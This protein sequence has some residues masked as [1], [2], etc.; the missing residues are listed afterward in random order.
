MAY[1]IKVDGSE[2]PIEGKLTLEV[3]QKA[4]GGYIERCPSVNKGE[5]LI[6]NEEGILKGLALNTKATNMM[7]SSMIPWGHNVLLGDVIV[8]TKKEMN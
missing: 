4:V 8:A 3:M 7:H 6:F 5:M 2:V 1:I